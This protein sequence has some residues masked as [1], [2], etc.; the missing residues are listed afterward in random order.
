M[1]HTR[2]FILIAMVL[3]LALACAIPVFAQKE[4]SPP[5]APT[6]GAGQ[7]DLNKEQPAPMA[8]TTGV[9]PGA[10]YKAAPGG[11]IKGGALMSTD[12][13]TPIR[14]GYTFVRE[15]NFVAA[16]HE[17]ETAAKL[18]ELNPFALNNL[19]VLDE[20]DGKLNDALAHFK[21][22]SIHAAQY[23]DKVA[24]TCFVGGSCMAVEPQRK[25]A[26]NSEILPIIQENITKLEA[27]IAATKTPP[28][29][30]TPPPMMPQ[31]KAK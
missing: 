23:R 25:M 30:E 18:D 15:G 14:R 22:A 24:Q 20:R 21:D 1:R 16:R 7:G 13:Y 29:A 3:A 19:A 6:T 9:G 11:V 12:V 5:M 27:K 28:P 10:G 26:A 31:P 4:G 17:F 2:K 8:P